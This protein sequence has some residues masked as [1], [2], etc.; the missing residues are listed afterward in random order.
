MPES[1]I[2][3]IADT[4][5][6]IPKAFALPKTTTEDCLRQAISDI[7]SIIQDPL[8]TLPFLYYRYATKNYINHIAH[9]LQII[10]YQSR[11]PILTLPPILPQLY[12]PTPMSNIITCTDAPAPRLEP[13]VQ[14]LRV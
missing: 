11:L 13:V 12:T 6:Y 3:C 10:K 14:P 5:K 7:L 4:L 1:G 9:I 2:F 8:K